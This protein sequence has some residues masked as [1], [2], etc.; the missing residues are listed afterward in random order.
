MKINSKISQSIFMMA[1]LTLTIAVLWAF[2]GV[3]D[4][5]NKTEKPVVSQKEINPIKAGFD[6]SV[7]DQ[8]G[9]LQ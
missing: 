7:L 8:L 4:A 6:K 5:L 9:Q 3:S 2:L 1:I